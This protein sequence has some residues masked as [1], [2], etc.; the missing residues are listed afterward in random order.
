[1][2]WKNHCLTTSSA[3]LTRKDL[4]TCSNNIE[5]QNKFR[6]RPFQIIAKHKNFSVIDGTHRTYSTH[7]SSSPKR[8]PTTSAQKYGCIL[9]DD[10]PCPGPQW[11]PQ[12]GDVAPLAKSLKWIDRYALTEEHP[13]VSHIC[14]WVNS[15]IRPCSSS[16]LISAS[17]MNLTEIAKF[18]LERSDPYPPNTDI[19]PMTRDGYDWLR[20]VQALVEAELRRRGWSPKGVRLFPSPGLMLHNRS[21]RR[22][23]PPPPAP[24]PRRSSLPQHISARNRSVT[25]GQPMLASSVTPHTPANARPVLG[26]G[27]DSRRP[28]RFP[29]RVRSPSPDRARWNPREITRSRQQ[30][31]SSPRP[32]R[33]R[34]F[35]APRINRR[36]CRGTCCGGPQPEFIDISEMDRRAEYRRSRTPIATL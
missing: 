29:S 14:D 18:Q 22:F 23:L 7:V 34:I 13:A 19:A 28:G 25:F 27:R 24:P 31:A 21:P 3:R 33:R 15:E 36:L 8:K 2:I 32:V 16:E 12:L 35:P 5:A 10:R 30:R 26:R 11:V 20:S 6:V 1:M 17:K 9:W 4:R